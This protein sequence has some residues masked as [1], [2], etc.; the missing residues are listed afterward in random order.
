MFNQAVRTNND[1]EGWHGMLNR[2]ANKANLAFYV[3]VKLLEE[4]SQLVDLTI[5]LVSEKKMKRR[6]RKRYKQ[7]EGKL[8]PAWKQYMDGEKGAKDLLRTCSHLVNPK[9]D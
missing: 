4:Q 6:Q 8:F 9:T 1:L 7:T 5:R 3:L 2:H